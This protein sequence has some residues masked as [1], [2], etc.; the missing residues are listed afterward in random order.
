VPI[1]GESG[2]EMMGELPMDWR[3]AYPPVGRPGS[4]DGFDSRVGSDLR[5]RRIVS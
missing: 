2:P 4:W 5:G 3:E 1:R